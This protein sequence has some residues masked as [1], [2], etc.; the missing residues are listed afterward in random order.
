MN[1][2]N[3]A[4][5]SLWPAIMLLIL[6]VIAWVLRQHIERNKSGHGNYEYCSHGFCIAPTCVGMSS[7]LGEQVP[8]VRYHLRRPDGSYFPVIYV[9]AHGDD[10]TVLPRLRGSV[11]VEAKRLRAAGHTVVLTD[12]ST[13]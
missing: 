13:H 7:L 4:W 1:T 2:F 8:G 3:G 5:Q 12:Y 6:V 9:D 10:P 11:D